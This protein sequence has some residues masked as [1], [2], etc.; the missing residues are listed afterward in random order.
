MGKKSPAPPPAPDYATLAIKQGEANLAAAKQSAYMSNPN[1]YTP[2]GT[3]TVSWT[4]T[5]TVDT[6]AYNKAAAH[7][8]AHP[9]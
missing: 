9:C 6:D 2:T 8:P 3:Q 4:K 7:H 1:I 5:P